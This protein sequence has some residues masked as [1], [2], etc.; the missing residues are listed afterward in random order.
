[1]YI[2]ISVEFLKRFDAACNA[3]IHSNGKNTG[4][5]LEKKL[6]KQIKCC[7]TSF[8][9]FNPADCR[10]ASIYIN[11]RNMKKENTKRTEVQSQH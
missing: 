2:Y 5:F 9:G 3:S 11:A 1:M 10:K 4:F 8:L 7:Y 6:S